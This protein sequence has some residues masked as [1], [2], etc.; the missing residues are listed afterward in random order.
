MSAWLLGPTL[1][2]SHTLLPISC[3]AECDINSDVRVILLSANS[4][5]TKFGCNLKKA[6]QQCNFTYL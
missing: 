4:A 6:K 2:S 1:G 5:I 3:L